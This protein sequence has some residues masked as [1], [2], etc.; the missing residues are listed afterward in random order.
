[1]SFS[2]GTFSGRELV[3]NDVRGPIG[4]DLWHLARLPVREAHFE[5][6]ARGSLSGG[7]GRLGSLD[8]LVD[9]QLEDEVQR[10]ARA[11]GVA[12]IPIYPGGGRCG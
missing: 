1:M 9:E 10:L 4:A 8:S 2:G 6:V 3:P 5:A 12:T 7:T 11:H